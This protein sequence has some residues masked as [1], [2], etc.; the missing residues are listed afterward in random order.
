M[1]GKKPLTLFTFA[2]LVTNITAN[3]EQ[4][5]NSRYKIAFIFLSLAIF[6]VYSTL[7][8]IYIFRYR[9]FKN[10]V[11][12]ENHKSEH[13]RYFLINQLLHNIRENLEQ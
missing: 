12:K 13:D 2:V 3:L 8:L 6:M 4:S 11:T 5:T 7:L 10:T 1:I 9:I